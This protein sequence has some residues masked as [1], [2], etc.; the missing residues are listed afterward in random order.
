M[1]THP[2]RNF[3]TGLLLYFFWA[4]FLTVL[5]GIVLNQF[6]LLTP[7]IPAL[8]TSIAGFITIIAGAWVVVER[9]FLPQK[10]TATPRPRLSGQEKTAVFL[11]GL[12]T[13]IVLSVFFVELLPPILGN[14]P[15]GVVTTFCDDLRRGDT[16]DAYSQ[17]SSN[18][19]MQLLWIYYT[20]YHVEGV[21]Q[22]STCSVSSVQMGGQSADV[23]VNATEDIGQG[24]GF[25]GLVQENGVWK[26][27]GESFPNLIPYEFCGAISEQRSSA[28]DYFSPDLQSKVTRDEF[29]QKWLD[30]QMGNC[31]TS[32]TSWSGTQA[33]FTMQTTEGNFSS[34]TA[35]FSGKLVADSYGIWTIQSIQ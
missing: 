25:F 27:N 7:P 22:P 10:P 5:A 3:R 21:T 20:V 14:S 28:Y 32:I 13:A 1:T 12:A 23:K 2:S 16:V 11:M 33:S 6:N 26:I 31:S 29:R 35:H 15:E 18:S 30:P 19:N 34:S 9:F 4:G 24:V 17:L 8:A